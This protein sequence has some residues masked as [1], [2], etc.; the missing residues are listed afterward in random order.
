MLVIRH[1]FDPVADALAGLLGARL[2]CLTIETWL[3]GCA[4]KHTVGQDGVAS[5]IRQRDGRA[6]L[7]GA[8][9]IVLNRVRHVSVPAFHHA[10]AANRDYAAAEATAAF[11]SCLEGLRCPVLNS[12]LALRLMGQGRPS[13]A[14]A[15]HAVLAGLHTQRVRM[16]TRARLSESGQLAPFG[17]GGPVPAVGTPALV[18][19][20]GVDEPSAVWVIGDEVL[21]ALDG[22][23]PAAVARFAQQIGL[24]FGTV[25]FARRA[26]GIWAW[27]GFDAAPAQAPAEAIHSL[28]RYLDRHSGQAIRGARG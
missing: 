16:T 28:A 19:D 18:F 17:G 5:D 7:D 21:G 9:S 26:D 12:T 11:W 2:R 24:G 23:E 20:P 4:F 27:C 1:F 25:L 6:L 8:T 22:V 15:K 14:A 13:L 10:S 3:T